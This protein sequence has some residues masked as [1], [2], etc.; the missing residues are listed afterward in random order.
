M[1]VVTLDGFIQGGRVM[2]NFVIAVA[3]LA[4]GVALVGCAPGP[5]GGNQAE[6]WETR[7]D[8]G[9]DATSALHFRTMG[10]G[11][12]ASTANSGAAIFWQPN[13]MAK[14]DYTIS[15]SFTQTEP[16]GHPTAYGLFFGS[17]FMSRS[18]FLPK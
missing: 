16:S 5:Q 12:H 17:W 7:L 14:G 11:V 15:A 1:L 2:R 13:S 9:T 18:D 10:N 6:G 8:G 4:L 3:V